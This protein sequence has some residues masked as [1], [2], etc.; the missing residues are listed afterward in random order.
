M[1]NKA[2]PGTLTP[3]SA[4]RIAKIKAA[5]RGGAETMKDLAAKTKL[6][7]SAV[8]HSLWIE[9]H[10]VRPAVAHSANP[11]ARAAKP[12]AAKKTTKKTATRS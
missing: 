2:K 12:K 7:M 1:A 3:Q 6:S 11:R 9:R 8:R 4:E 5:R 10:G